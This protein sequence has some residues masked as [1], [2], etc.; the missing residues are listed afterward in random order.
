VSRLRRTRPLLAAIFAGPVALAGSG[1]LVGEIS[2]GGQD[3]EACSDNRNQAPIAPRVLT[4][5]HRALDVLPG[6]LVIQASAFSDPDEEAEHRATQAEI[7]RLAG[8][9][10]LFRVWSATQEE[11]ARLGELRLSDG[12]FEV[13][14]TLDENA[15]YEVTVR[16]RDEASCSAWSP[17]SEPVRFRTDDGSSYWY[18]GGP[19]RDVRIDIPPDSWDPINAQSRPPDCVP[20]ERQYYPGSVTIDGE[21]Y[22]GVGIRTKG[23]CGSSRSLAGKASFKINL[24]WDDPEVSGCPDNRRSHGLKRLTL[25]NQVQDRSFVH[26]RLAYHFYRLMGVPVPRAEHVRVHVNGELWGLYLNLE[27]IDRRMLS[28]WFD[29]NQGMLYEGT[30]YCDLLPDNIPPGEQDDTNYCI[31]RKF[32]STA[33]SPTEEGADPETFAPIRQLAARLSEMPAG[34]FYPEIE[35]VFEFDTFLSQWAAENVMGHWDGYAIQIVNNYRIYHDPIAKKWSIIPTGVDQSFQQRTQL[36]QVA[37]LLAQ[38]CWEEED[39]RAAFLAR[40][41]QAVEV[42]EQANLAE[43]A[44]RIRDQ[45]A[46]HVDADP[47]KEGSMADFMNGVSDT[48]NFIDS[49]PAEVRGNLGL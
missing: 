4:P 29:S 30:Y 48:I 47:R 37:G 33:C 22:P 44:T 9:E 13:G 7:W 10:P 46:P 11:P 41:A 32:H 2:T 17:W 18:G 38:R 23:G 42:F 14:E 35:Q 43:M 45:I 5:A 19:V 21:S 36:N 24:S 12:T 1:C 20:F 28:R 8:G 16:H 39:C 34:S 49:R 6:D 40:V 3:E 25:N 31:S 26:E 15:D 27:S